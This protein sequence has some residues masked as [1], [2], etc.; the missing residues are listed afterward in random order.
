MC[1][2]L[3]MRIM[4]VS[5]Q[6]VDMTFACV[7]SENENHASFLA[8]GPHVISVLSHRKRQPLKFDRL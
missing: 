6:C 7:R 4:Q 8:L 2:V 1:Y 5:S 3:K